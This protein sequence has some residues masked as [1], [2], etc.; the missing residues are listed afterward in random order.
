MA[1]NHKHCTEFGGSL[2]YFHEFKTNEDEV[3][4]E[5]LVH[6]GLMV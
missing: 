4:D 2:R 1:L 6:M 5:V 3:L